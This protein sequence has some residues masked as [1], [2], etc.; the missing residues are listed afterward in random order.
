MVKNKKKEDRSD[1]VAVQPE[2]KAT[3]NNVLLP[4][5]KAAKSAYQFFQKENSSSIQQELNSSASASGRPPVD[6]GSLGREVSFR[7]Q[8]LSPSERKKYEDLA[9]KDKNRFVSESHQR[10][11]EALERKE[12]LRKER[13]TLILE[14]DGNDMEGGRATRRT[15]RKR[16]RKAEKKRAKKEQ[17]KKAKKA[18]AVAPRKT[19]EDDDSDYASD[20]SE[21]AVS[22]TY[23]DSESSAE[24]SSCSSSSSDSSSDSS[25]NNK[26]KNSARRFPAKVSQAVLD[27]RSQARK[28]KL[29]K[30]KYIEERLSNVRNERAEQAKRRLEFLLKQSDIFSHFGNVKQEKAR[31]GLSSSV[32]AITTS[33]EKGKGED[34]KTIV[35]KPSSSSAVGGIGDTKD[36]EE[37]ERQEVDEHEAT[38]LTTQPST[39]RGKMRQYQ[40][41]GLNVSQLAIPFFDLTCCVL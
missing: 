17:R 36:A 41:E 38:Y 5:I 16:E 2:S 25:S 22:S 21:D 23:E 26:K 15:R 4:P 37:E 18:A 19:K 34:C 1:W 14:D 27:R 7:W 9:E 8:N 39:L 33:L 20:D 6:V 13:E 11:V 32:A 10:D 40:L 31:L 28:G 12:R 30:E 24:D 29:Q 35:R 3:S